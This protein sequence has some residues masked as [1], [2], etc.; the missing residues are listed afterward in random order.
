[1][2]KHFGKFVINFQTSG[3]VSL[4]PPRHV[5]Q[6]DRPRLDRRLDLDRV[7]ATL[8]LLHRG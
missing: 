4:S 1:M 2:Q 6:G 5:L 8:A 3:R 7:Q